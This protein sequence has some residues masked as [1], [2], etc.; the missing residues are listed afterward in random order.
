[1]EEQRRATTVLRALEDAITAY[2]ELTKRLN[3]LLRSQLIIVDE[4][5]N[6][7][8]KQDQ[9]P[10][11]NAREVAFMRA[12]VQGADLVL[13]SSSPSMEMIYQAREGK[14]N[15]SRGAKKNIP[16]IMIV[17]ARAQGGFAGKKNTPFS[18]LLKD[19]IFSAI[20]AKEKV[21]LFL[22]RKG[23]ATSAICL[24]C[25]ANIKC[26]RCSVNLVYYRKTETL[27][28]HF[29]NFKMPSPKICPSCNA[30]YIRYS[31]TGTEKIESDLSVLF[32]SAVIKRVEAADKLDLSCADIFVSTS[33]I[34]ND[35]EVKFGLTGVLSIDSSMNH[36]DF[37]SA[38]RAFGILSCLLSITEKKM[39]IQ[40]AVP[41]H[42]LFAAFL[43]NDP[44]IFYDEELKQR[45]DLSLP[46]YRHLILVKL[47][48]IN[49]EKVKSAENLN[50][51]GR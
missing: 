2:S 41:G 39:I 47:R 32:P 14:L 17:D 37:R 26:P 33:A 23:F 9:S 50:K 34:K 15:Y 7:V 40:T 35:A 24:S 44:G 29:C 45:K 22:N 19:A 5:E 16:Q 25:G 51:R 6:F 42:H 48:G 1:M 8:Y 11:Y 4:E 13:G 43:K 20:N 49:E 46:P 36:A 30:G 28:C 38:E 10:H 21:L 18:K 12:R 3:E 27:E 31:G